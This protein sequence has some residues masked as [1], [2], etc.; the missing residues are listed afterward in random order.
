M[1]SDP[2]Y[3]VFFDVPL[4]KRTHPHTV[5]ADT[6]PW[7]DTTAA[8]PYVTLFTSAN[9]TLMGHDAGWFNFSTYS[10]RNPPVTV[11]GRE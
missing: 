2:V 7:H 6:S 9:S 11:R 5:T 3:S 4:Q 1:S 10:S 8:A